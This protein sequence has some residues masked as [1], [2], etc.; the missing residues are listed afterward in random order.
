MLK[1]PSNSSRLEMTRMSTNVFQLI[2]NYFN[3]DLE[4]PVHG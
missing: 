2:S 1:V 4:R 3:V